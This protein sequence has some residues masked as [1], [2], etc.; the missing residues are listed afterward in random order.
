M[1]HII[2]VL[3]STVFSSLQ[4]VGFI[5]FPLI[6]LALVIVMFIVVFII[7]WRNRRGRI[8]CY[9]KCRVSLTYDCLI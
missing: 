8:C 9:E 3:C 4:K 7:V 1:L 2:L 6:V 5:A